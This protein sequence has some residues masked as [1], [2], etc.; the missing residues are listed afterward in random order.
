MS[1]DTAV[2]YTFSK[3]IAFKDE[4]IESLTFR[5]LLWGDVEDH[6]GEKNMNAM[7]RQL[8]ASMSDMDPAFFRL[9]PTRE[10]KQLLIAVAP[11]MGNEEDMAELLGPAKA[12]A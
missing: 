5:E 10:I 4:T 6:E 8:L 3:P 11:L 9:V 7:N 2:T 1:K 12:S